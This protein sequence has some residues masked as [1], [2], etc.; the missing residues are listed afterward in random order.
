[1][2]NVLPY[3][4]YGPRARRVHLARFNSLGTFTERRREDVNLFLLRRRYESIVTE[5]MVREV[6]IAIASRLLEASQAKVNFL[7]TRL[8]GK[9]K[10]WSLGKIVVNEH[11]FPT[12]DAI[13]DDLRLAFEP[14]QEENMVY[15]R[16]LSMRQGKMSMRDYVQMARH[17][18]SCIITHPM[19]M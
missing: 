1:M 5:S 3:M 18:A 19:D 8:I 14:P 9:T 16:F 12:L 17:I 2:V 6:D 10:E 15:S 11:A 7:L 4:S 13:Q